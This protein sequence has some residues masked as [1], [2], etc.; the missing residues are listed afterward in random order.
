VPA[1]TRAPDALAAWSPRAAHAHAGA[2]TRS[3]AVWWGLVGGK[4]LSAST[5]EVPGWRRASGVYAGLTL[6][7]A[8]CEGSERWRRRRG[9]GRRRGR[10]GSG[11]RRSGP[12]AHGGG[13]GAGCGAVSE[14]RRGNHGVG[15]RIS[16]GGGGVPFLKGAGGRRN[17]GGSSDVADAWRKRGTSRG[18][19]ADRRAAAQNWRARATCAVRA[20]P[21]EQRGRG[22]ADGWAATTVL[23]GSEAAA[24]VGHAWASPGNRRWAEPR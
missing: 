20:L 10:E 11:E 23:G 13:E 7:V 12:V 21:T 19:P 3:T 16:V 2:V 9:G 1:A 18:V 4:V 14:R 17:G 24:C 15:G 8:R 6:A 5:G 22:E